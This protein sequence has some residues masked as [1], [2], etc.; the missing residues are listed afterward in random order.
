MIPFGLQ[1]DDFSLWRIEDAKYPYLGEKGCF[2]VG[3]GIVFAYLG[4]AEDFNTLLGNTGPGYQIRSQDGT[5]AYWAE[6]E[7]G[8]MKLQ[9]LINGVSS[10]KWQTQSIKRIRGTPIVYVKQFSDLVELHSLTSSPPL[11]P[12]IVREY[13][14]RGGRF[15]RGVKVAVVPSLNK[16]F[17]RLEDASYV[18]EQN[19]KRLI[20]SASS[21]LRKRKE[22]GWWCEP[23]SPGEELSFAI[24]YSFLNEEITAPPIREMEAQE[25]REETRKWWSR[26]NE[27]RVKF[28]TPDERFNDLMNDLPVLIEVQ[29]DLRSGAV[30]PMVSYHGFWIRD[31]NGPILSLLANGKFTEVREMLDYYRRAVG[32]FGTSH[33]LIPLDLNINE[34]P[35]DV[36]LS[37]VAVEIAEVPSWIV[38]Q[39]YWYY[40]YTGD[41]DLIRR[42]FPLLKRN[43]FGMALD[44]NYGAKF[45]GDETYTHGALY[46]TFD[47]PE[48]G[49]LGFPNGYLPTEFYS[50]DNTL[51]HREAA[52]ALLEL[53][54]EIGDDDTQKESAE[55]A[56]KLSKILTNYRLENNAY[57]PAISPISLEKWFLP[58]SNVSLR[59]YWLWLSPLEEDEWKDYIWAKDEILSRWRT[60]TTPFSGYCTGHNLA[61]WLTAAGELNDQLGE[62]F[63]AAIQ[64][65]ASPE[66]AWCEVYSPDGSP[67]AIYG[68]INRIR[69]W[70]SGINYEAII[71]YLTGI[72]FAPRGEWRLMPRLPQKWASYRIRN[73]RAGESVFDLSVSKDELGFLKINLDIH[74]GS[75]PPSWT[76]LRRINLPEEELTMVNGATALPKK[77]LSGIKLLVFTKDGSFRKTLNADRRF[78]NLSPR[79]IAVWDIG[80]P[81]TIQDIREAILGVKGPVVPYIYFD[82]GVKEADRR[83]FKDDKFWNSN[84]LKELLTEFIRVGGNIVD[85]NTLQINPSLGVLTLRVLVVLYTNTFT[86]KMEEKDIENFHQEIGE[87][88]KWMDEVAGEKLSLKLDYLQI[89]RWL[90]PQDSGPLGGGLYWMSSRDVENDLIIRGIDRDYYDSI[91]AFWAWD[92]DAR[93]DAEQAYGGAAEG[94]G[95]DVSIMAK[96]SKVSYFGAA[97]LK[98]HPD[99]ISKVALHEYLHN[100]DAM[101]N[102]AG[103][104]NTFISSDD[105]AKSMERL[106]SERPGAFN[107]LGFSDEEMIELARKEI[108]KEASFPWRTQLVFYRWLLE[109]TSKEDFLRIFPKLGTIAQRTERDVL[110]ERMYLPNNS[111]AFQIALSERIGKGMGLSPITVIDKDDD[112]ETPNLQEKLWFGSLKSEGAN[113]VR[114]SEAEIIA[115]EVTR[116]YL[117]EGERCFEVLVKY[118]NG[119]AITPP[120]TPNVYALVS[121]QKLKFSYLGEGKFRTEPI[122]L[123]GGKYEVTVYAQHEG[124]VISPVK[125]A[126]EITPSWDLKVEPPLKFPMGRGNSFNL[127]LESKDNS[128]KF[129]L[130]ADAEPFKNSLLTTWK[131][132][133]RIIPLFEKLRKRIWWCK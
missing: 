12:L 32:H 48:S 20:I 33:M 117:D 129:N 119:E 47:R 22:G 118:T 58:F 46:S 38:L 89:D 120:P 76:A 27:D 77:H 26:W 52:L 21:E 83:S 99:G 104:E 133:R 70:E 39:H 103:L 57:A 132:S 28:E 126:L 19:E 96:P 30:S 16:D 93:K 68:R 4:V 102:V 112:Y 44:E 91:I 10:I 131:R 34:E 87:W 64:R 105:M 25:L 81:F 61:Y 6:S 42:A 40:R 97:V 45:H 66:G 72:T 123:P 82:S 62:R 59:K 115:E 7:W 24:F 65:L 60:G 43:L 14:L 74:P 116:L 111:K 75:T 11:K 94:P 5:P 110:Y 56:D 63:L 55:L 122:N 41:R 13:V 51:I 49:K 85:E 79:Q 54:S 36:S 109:R 130:S 95:E 113:V 125:V 101:F 37:R 98:S 121:N 17:S 90:P 2:P 106:L 18:I 29:R 3:N 8:E 100:I 108:N 80:M 69:P 1:E 71:R 88:I 124:A 86:W 50:L 128:D 84:E 107:S 15:A 127:I 67:V 73:L 53:S 31:S 35:S 92:R 114:Y 78:S 9:F 23:L